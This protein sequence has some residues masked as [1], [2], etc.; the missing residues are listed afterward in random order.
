MIVVDSALL[1]KGVHA[2]A[3]YSTNEREHFERL[4]EQLIDNTFDTRNLR[5]RKAPAQAFNERQVNVPNT[6]PSNLQLLG[7]TPTKRHK[8]SHPKHLMQGRCVVCGGQ[9]TH[10][11]RECQ[12][13][14]GPTAKKQIWICDKADHVCMGRHILAA[15]PDMGP[16]ANQRR[17]V[18]WQNVI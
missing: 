6:I 16:N 14:L 3:A 8:K 15:H 11:C 9:S 10:V 2:G 17:A 5:A 13:G 12:S 4:S 18:T 7:V 1:H